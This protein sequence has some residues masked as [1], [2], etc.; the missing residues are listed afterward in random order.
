MAVERDAAEGLRARWGCGRSRSL[1]LARRE[2]S[3]AEAFERLIGAPSGACPG[4]PFEGV[5]HPEP[6][7][8]E[9]LSARVMVSDLS[10]SWADAL[11]R[12]LTHHDVIALRW[13]LTA[14]ARLDAIP[15]DHD[16]R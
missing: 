3:L 15:K 2:R 13:W 8:S 12:E 6:W 10:L 16:E 4:C 1:P 11:G 9:L 7:L 5:Y 14:R